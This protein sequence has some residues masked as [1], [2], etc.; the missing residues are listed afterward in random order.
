MRST[1]AHPAFTLVELLIVVA[2]AGVLAALLM[3]AFGMALSIANR[4]ACT[5]NLKQLGIA[6]RNYANHHDGCYPLEDQCGNPQAVLVPALVPHYVGDMRLFYCPSAAQMEPY[7]RSEEYGGPGGDSVVDTPENRER[8]FIT[9]KYYSVGRRDTRQPLPLWLS[10]YPHQLGI[11]S[12]G[13]RWLMSD[14]VRKDIPAFPHREPGGWGGGRNVLF[15][16]GSVQFVRQ[17]T[18]GAFTERP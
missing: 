8:Y 3:P 1:G 7:A 4:T 17:R 16:D 10:E 12:P 2:M 5:N 14:Y 9:Y 18:T 15:A 11:D 6:L 13:G